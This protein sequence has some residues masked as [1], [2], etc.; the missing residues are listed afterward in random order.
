[1]KSH[2]QI[3]L[4]LGILMILFMSCHMIFA[5]KNDASLEDINAKRLRLNAR[6]MYVLGGW[7][8]SNIAIGT[9]MRGRSQGVQ[10]YFHEGNAGWNI[11]NLAIAGG[12]L[13]A[14]A[15][16]DPA[17]FDMWQTFA[18]Q[19]KIE[20]FLLFNAG[21]DVGYMATGLYLLE[22]GKNTSGTQ[23][24]RFKGYGQALLLQ[25]G[26]LF[27]FDITVFLLHN[28][29]AAPELQ[30]LLSSVYVTGDGLGM[31]LRF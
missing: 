29:Q 27:A 18:E 15:K 16:A 30:Q 3:P 5:Q 8:V 11:I 17:S 7:A 10:R 2:T 19:Q 1:M 6:S 28:S 9:I 20:K 23:S 26:F 21:L 13:L 22:R 4:R 24:D 25:G 31:R 14:G 12:S